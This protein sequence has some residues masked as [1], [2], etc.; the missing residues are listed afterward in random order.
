MSSIDRDDNTKDTKV[1]DTARKGTAK[2]VSLKVAEA[3]QR[4][5]GRKLHA[6]IRK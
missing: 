4:D 1:T 6:S 3:E 2:G 5:V